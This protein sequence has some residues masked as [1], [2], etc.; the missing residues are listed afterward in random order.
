MGPDPECIPLSL[1]FYMSTVSSI[2]LVIF[3]F[4]LGLSRVFSCAIA[5]HFVRFWVHCFF[6]WFGSFMFLGLSRVF[7]CVSFCRIR[8]YLLFFIGYTVSSFGLVLSRCK[9]FRIAS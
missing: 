1:L 7:Y 6:F 9:F 3:V 2:G 5:L 8:L 4:L